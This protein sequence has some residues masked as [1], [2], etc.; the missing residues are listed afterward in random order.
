MAIGAIPCTNPATCPTKSKTHTSMAELAKCSA[1]RSGG[2]DAG[3][4]RALT[5]TPGP[6]A[7]RPA[8]AEPQGFLLTD[9]G[10]VRDL[11]DGVATVDMDMLDDN[12]QDSDWAESAARAEALLRRFGR[13]REA[14]LMS[15]ARA[16]A[17]ED[18]PED[19]RGKDSTPDISDV[20]SL[21]MMEGGLVQWQSDG[22]EV[23]SL[24][25]LEEGGELDE[26]ETALEELERFGRTSEARLVRDWLRD[27]EDAA[28]QIDTLSPPATFVLVEGGMVQDQSDSVTAIDMDELS[29]SDGDDNWEELASDAL[30]LFRKF[31]MK[32]EADELEPRLRAQMTRDWGLGAGDAIDLPDVSDVHTLAV[33]SRGAVNSTFGDVTVVDLDFLAVNGGDEQ[34]L[35]EARSALTTL[36]THGLHDR[37]DRVR[38]WLAENE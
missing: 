29:D 18:L 36:A 8:D 6:I 35:E 4:P 10:M 15:K 14:D 34:G 21:A 24:D 7:G 9:S 22:V 1:V 33:M 19:E 25:F 30:A 27:H 32:D 31:G 12:V 2:V 20:T 16:A 3:A 17:V 37:A 28:P 11:S 5:S 13:D 38:K 26:A 23:I